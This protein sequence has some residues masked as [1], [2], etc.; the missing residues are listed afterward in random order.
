MDRRGFAAIG[1]ACALALVVSACADDSSE[2]SGGGALKVGLLTSLSGAASAGFNGAEAGVKARFAAYQ[3]DK[4]K[5]SSRTVQV[6]TADDQSNAQGALTATQKLIQQ[7]KVYS[8]LEISA[9]FYGAAQYAT[10]AGKSTPIIGGGFDGA[11]QWNDTKNNLLPAGIVPDYTKT[12]ST[13]GDYFKQVGGTKV[14]GISTASPSAQAGLEAGL[15]SAEAA[16]LKRGYVNTS[17]PIGSNDVGAIVLGIIKSGSDVVSLAINP[18]TTFAIVAGLKQAG[19]K[20][21]AV[22][23]PTGYGADLLESAPAIQAG[24]DVTFS[25]SWAPSELKTP[26]TERLG[27]ALKKHAG[28]KSGIPSFSQAY[29][30]FAADLLLHG[31]EKAGCDASQAKFISTVRADK[32]WTAN[33]L[34]P[35]ARDFTTIATPKQCIYY[36]RMKGSAFV[37]EANATPIC[38]AIVS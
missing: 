27:L 36:L 34:F 1:A 6:V 19:Y 3:E 30:W 14:A 22:L 35:S 7:D 28:S 9:L 17:V 33:G 16:G 25:T 5:C 4:G 20:T 10:T 29:G 15:K 38:G 32:T 2:T 8:V 23:S 11:K 37:P 18:D 13:T 31:L 12:Y 21:K 24:Q 26:A